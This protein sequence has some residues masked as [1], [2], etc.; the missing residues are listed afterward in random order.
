M[1]TVANRV[2]RLVE[3]TLASPVTLEEAEQFARE[4]IALM[5]TIPGKFVGV[6]D[7]LGAH[8]VPQD[9]ADRI[10]RLLSANAGR[11]ERSA[12]LIGDS[13]LLALQ[14]ERLLRSAN[15]PNRRAFRDPAEL[16]AWLNEVLNVQEQA[17][18]QQFL[19]KATGS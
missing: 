1:H 18:L 7:L 19:R 15:Q 6:T 16:A 11:V 2:G 9:V 5:E 14:V 13:A 17:E 4:N 8:V 3:V 12:M 10:I